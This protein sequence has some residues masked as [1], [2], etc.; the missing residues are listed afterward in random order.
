M[1]TRKA[2][3]QSLKYGWFSRD[4]Q[5]VAKELSG[6]GFTVVPF[7]SEEIV[8]LVESGMLTFETPFKGSIRSMRKI[9]DLLGLPAP[10]NMDFPEWILRSEKNKKKFL[11]RKVYKT[12]VAQVLKHFGDRTKKRVFKGIPLKSHLHVKSLLVQKAFTGQIWEHLAHFSESFPDI[13]KTINYLSLK[14]LKCKVKNEFM[15]KITE[16]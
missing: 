10:E 3:V 8:N 4:C 12:T 15:F 16:Y 6:R 13:Q 7:H 2:F 11:G 14:L 9:I 1:K 5:Q